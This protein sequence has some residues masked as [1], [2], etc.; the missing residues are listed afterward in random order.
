MKEATETRATIS[1]RIGR[2]T[3]SKDMSGTRNKIITICRALSKTS[4]RKVLVHFENE[5]HPVSISYK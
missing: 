2:E 4:K 1:M 3:H 5:Q